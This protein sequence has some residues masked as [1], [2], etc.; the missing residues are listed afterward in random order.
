VASDWSEVHLVRVNPQGKYTDG[1]TADWSDRISHDISPVIQE[2]KTAHEK[3]R[4]V[5]GMKIFGNGTF[6]DPADRDKSVRFAM[7]CKEIDAV[8]IGFK[9]KEEIDGG[10]ELINRALA[11]A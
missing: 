3:G 10:I 4:G 1:E 2:I 9:S 7:A 8:V 5:I 6:L 11:E